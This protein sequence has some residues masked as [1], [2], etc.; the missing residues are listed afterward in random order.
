MVPVVGR[1]VVGY[2]L[3]SGVLHDDDA[4]ARGDDATVRGDDDVLDNLVWDDSAHFRMDFH[5]TV[6][7]VFRKVVEV[8][9]IVVHFQ[10]DSVFLKVHRSP[11]ESHLSQIMISIESHKI[12]KH[13]IKAQTSKWSFVKSESRFKICTILFTFSFFSSYANCC[14]SISFFS[15]L[16]W[17]WCYR[18]FFFFIVWIYQSSLCCS[19]ET[20]AS[21][22]RLN[23]LE[24]KMNQWIR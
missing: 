3:D 5:G 2:G 17:N 18:V 10:I 12:T 14:C 22:T 6:E 9:H 13:R 19:P 21:K 7:G 16:N 4:K 20:W 1:L 24:I 8:F 11:L 23:F 15:I